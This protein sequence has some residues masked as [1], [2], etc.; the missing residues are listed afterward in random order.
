FV[1]PIPITRKSRRVLERTLAGLEM[2]R[3][4]LIHEPNVQ[5][6]LVL[7]RD[8]NALLKDSPGLLN[9]DRTK[10]TNAL[11][12]SSSDEFLEDQLGSWFEGFRRNL[13][14]PS[15]E[16]NF[17]SELSPTGSAMTSLRDVEEQV[18]IKGD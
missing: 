6:S 9:D 8:L 16:T 7:R 17:I 3:I 13:S 18:V 14:E 11:G 1:E 12:I 5:K 10:I 15:G 4:T 2:A